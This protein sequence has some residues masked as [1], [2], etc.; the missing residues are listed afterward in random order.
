M[1]GQPKNRTRKA[2]PK[3]VT[4]A[5]RQPASSELNVKPRPL[6]CGFLRGSFKCDYVE[7]QLVS[8]DGDLT[9][10]WLLPSKA[11]LCFK[12]I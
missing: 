10:A 2:A 12:T 4:L 9:E 6:T 5:R 3:V 1:T 7:G 11:E 8:K